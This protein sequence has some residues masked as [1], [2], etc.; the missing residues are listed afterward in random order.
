MSLNLNLTAASILGA[1]LKK[2]ASAVQRNLMGSAA[3]ALIMSLSAC[4]TL[5]GLQRDLS[6]QKLAPRVTNAQSQQATLQMGE[7]GG[8][9]T[10]TSGAT[11]EENEIGY[12]L[13]R[14]PRRYVEPVQ[15][16]PANARQN[17]TTTL[18]SDVAA[19]PTLTNP[20]GADYNDGISRIAPQ[21][22]V[23]SIE[24]YV[25]PLQLP[26]F[27]DIAFG[28]M[29]QVPFVIG[30]DVSA[31]TDIVQL[32]SSGKMTGADF[33]T[34]VIDALKEYGVRVVPENGSYKVIQDAALRSRVP[35]F[36]KSR[37]RAR[38]RSDLRPIIQFVEMQAVDANSMYGILMETFSSKTDVIRIKSNP[39]NNYLTLSGLPED[40]NVALSI[41]SQLDE[42]EFAGSQVRKYTPQYWN[43][44]EFSTVVEQALSVEGWEV[45]SN[46]GL[47]RTIFLMPVEYSNDLFIFAK[48]AQ[49]HARVTNWLAELDR[50]VQGGDAKQ[51][52][53][54]QVKNVAAEE[55]ANTANSVL[56]DR[57]DIGGISTAQGALDNNRSGNTN[58]NT[59]QSSGGDGGGLTS[60]QTRF[61]VDASGNRIIF[62]G[63]SSDYTK[64]RSL[65][66]Q[67]D[68]PAPEVLIEVQIA[69]VSLVNNTNLGLDFRLSDIGL[70]NVTATAET[71]GLGV[72]STGLSVGLLGND[73]DA[74]LNA[75]A[76]NRRVKLLSTP[77]LTARSGSAAEIQVGQ[78]IPVLSSQRASN[79]QDGVG[80][81][82]IL[83]SIEYRKTG[84]LLSIE[85]IVFSD[86]RIDLT[87]AQEVSSELD[88]GNSNISSPTIS[89]RS[90]STQLSL[91]DGQT[92]VM[93]GL[94]QRS[95]TV[96]DKGVP[97]FKDIPLVGRLFS[98]E[99]L[100]EDNTEL[101]VLITAY[102]LRGQTDKDQF[103]RRLSS[104]MDQLLVDD[105]R[106]LT[107]SPRKF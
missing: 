32:R 7:R 103:V 105:S 15:N 3:I 92:A 101:V 43:V 66:E 45:T 62:T 73:I 74:T 46:P 98:S 68:T 34:L 106:M 49:A 38:T 48:T 72:G 50:P 10:R 83:Q 99:G 70:G 61:T 93:G 100:S 26:Q 4:Q 59:R 16:N 71:A 54:Y 52:Y 95:F 29:L 67:L 51:I 64:L 94:I 84:V 40:V 53:I 91:E 24:A 47:S 33:Q 8:P 87:I 11:L 27:V 41:I 75:F 89:N 88:T 82:D 31:M 79:V 25:A 97:F 96:D 18:P 81:T 13:E 77:I 39:Q 76:S 86:N 6:G 56:S 23:R 69:E 12:G 107:L 58:I 104:G 30:K 44:D 65:L 63:T 36:I 9:Y 85:P 5:E 60:G 14:G 28:E 35:K 42:L 21:T 1:R 22:K 19:V 90:L 55:L 80:Q 20:N 2:P 78:D 102:V 57:A 17:Y 37:A